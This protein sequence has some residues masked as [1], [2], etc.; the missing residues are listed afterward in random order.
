MLFSDW[1]LI[2]AA[3]NFVI[4]ISIFVIHTRGIRKILFL[5]DVSPPK[6]YAS[7]PFVSILIAARNEEK[8]IEAALSTILNLDYNPKEIIIVNDRS[9]D[10]TG[11]ILERIKDKYR[12]L[13]VLTITEL[14][15]RWLGKNHAQWKAAQLARGEIF[16]FTDADVMMDPTALSRAVYYLEKEKRD[17]LAILPEIDLPGRFLTAIVVGFELFFNVFQRVW[18][19]RNSKSS[20]HVGVG[21]FNLIRRST[22]FN[23]GTHEAIRLRPDDDLKLGKLVKKTGHQQDFLFGCGQLKVEWYDSLSSMIQGLMKNAFSPVNYQFSWIAL[24]SILQLMFGVGPFFGVLV[25]HGLTQFLYMLSAM[26]LLFCCADNARR[27]GQ[28]PWG[29][30][31]LPLSLLLMIYIAWQAALRTLWKGGIE[32]RGTFTSLKEL[33]TNIV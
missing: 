28:S 21:A 6:H 10:K 2:L 22:Y 33:K 23:M 15:R 12:D 20:A 11:E 3:V 8:N 18:S 14:P 13:N 24:G 7:Q 30:L 5:K 29:A 31:V 16:L 32:W 1:V 19:V 17:H 25:T 4:T 26:A 9:I 27:Q